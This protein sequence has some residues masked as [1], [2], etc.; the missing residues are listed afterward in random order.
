MVPRGTDHR[1]RAVRPEPVAAVEDAAGG[2]GGG[3]AAPGT[4]PPSRRIAPRRGYFTTVIRSAAV[5]A[6][7]AEAEEWAVR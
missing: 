5:G 7:G 1:H 2:G 3:K 6:Y 4:G